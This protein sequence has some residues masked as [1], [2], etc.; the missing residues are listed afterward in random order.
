L[1]TIVTDA[2]TA[3]SG[4]LALAPEGSGV[5]TIDGLT[6]PAADGSAD[7]FMKTNGSGVLSFAAAGGGKV[8]QFVTAQ[9]NATST[10]GT[11]IPTDDSKPQKTEGDEILTLAITPANS[12]SKLFIFVTIAHWYNSSAAQDKVA[13]LFRDDAADTIFCIVDSTNDDYVKHANFHFQLA[14]GSTS[15]QTFKLRVGSPSG[16]VVVNRADKYD[17]ANVVTMSIMEVLP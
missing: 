14:A 1:S 6:Y 5:V 7:E 11:T 4:N 9:T 16:N 8:G 17:Q 12:S 10:N 13:A 15:E 2:V 3:L